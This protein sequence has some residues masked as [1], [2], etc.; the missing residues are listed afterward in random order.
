MIRRPPRSTL[1]PYTTLFRSVA[2]RI[3]PKCRLI[4]SDDPVCPECGWNIAAGGGPG[5]ASHPPPRYAGNLQSMALFTPLMFCA[6]L[7]LSFATTGGNQFLPA[8]SMALLVTGLIADAFLLLLIYKTAAMFAE[9]SRWMVGAV[10]TF[11]FGTLVFA[12]LL[13]RRARLG[14]PVGRP[15]PDDEA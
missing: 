14:G 2:M 13:A 3:C 10:L 4:A 8:V 12:W 6:S 7:I 1:F 5:P 9:A 11:P 15:T